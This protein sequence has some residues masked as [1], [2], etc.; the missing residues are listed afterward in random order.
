MQ[1]DPNGTWVLPTTHRPCFRN[2]KTL[3]LINARALKA[4]CLKE[5]LVQIYFILFTH[6][7]IHPP[8]SAAASESHVGSTRCVLSF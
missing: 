1:G 8:A 4:C 3:H 5:M 2:S 6:V 7:S